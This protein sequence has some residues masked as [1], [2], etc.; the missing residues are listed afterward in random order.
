MSGVLNL[1]RI[2]NLAL[3]EELEWQIA[4][5]FTAITD[6]TGAETDYKGFQVTGKLLGRE[7]QRR[8]SRKCVSV[9]RNAFHGSGDPS[10]GFSQGLA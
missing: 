3:V 2:K 1:P 9:N 6:E 10:A 7:K 4:P 8:Q 5:G